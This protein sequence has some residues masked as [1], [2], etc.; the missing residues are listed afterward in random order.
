LCGCEGNSA[1]Q[2]VQEKAAKQFISYDGLRIRCDRTRI[3][4]CKVRSD[5][6]RRQEREEKGPEASPIWTSAFWG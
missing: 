5:E 1:E 6:C 3:W 4:F 2:P